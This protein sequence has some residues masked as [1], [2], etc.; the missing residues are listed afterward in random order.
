M[1]GGVS[2]RSALLSVGAAGDWY[3]VSVGDGALLVTADTPYLRYLRQKMLIDGSRLAL[4]LG[5]EGD[6]LQRNTN[7]LPILHFRIANNSSQVAIVDRLRLEVA[8]SVVD[9]EPLLWTDTG[10]GLAN[11]HIRIGNYGWGPVNDVSFKFDIVSTRTVAAV[12]PESSRMFSLSLP[13]IPTNGTVELDFWHELGSH[14]ASTGLLRRTDLPIEIGRTSQPQYQ[15]FEHDLALLRQSFGAKANDSLS[16][17]GQ[18][19]YRQE[20]GVP[21][22]LWLYQEVRIEWP[23]PPVFPAMMS[24]AT[25]ELALKEKG[26]NYQVQ[27]DISYS[28]APGSAAMLDARIVAPKSSI[29]SLVAAVRMNGHWINANEPVR[30][31]FYR[32]TTLYVRFKKS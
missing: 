9:P 24:D 14:G 8:S 20:D 16:L 23:S 3:A 31:R 1:G 2:S 17:V 21:K 28:I 15:Q 12:Q 30:L 7:V 11:G 22:A 27:K 13:S 10:N 25:F 5:R 6:E 29:H 26:S 18:L 32:P 19:S 4:L